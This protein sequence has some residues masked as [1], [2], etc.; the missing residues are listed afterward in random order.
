MWTFFVV[1]HRCICRAAAFSIPPQVLG[2]LVYVFI[3]LEIF[4]DIWNENLLP[5][6]NIGFIM[7]IFIIFVIKLIQLGINSCPSCKLKFM[8]SLNSRDKFWIWASFWINIDFNKFKI[9]C[10]E[11]LRI[12]IWWYIHIKYPSIWIIS[13]Q[14]QPETSLENKPQIVHNFRMWLLCCIS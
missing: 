14:S 8:W 5:I 11:K 7:Q 2:S 3:I 9:Y 6:Y 13:S 10:L 1:D 12:Q 4:I